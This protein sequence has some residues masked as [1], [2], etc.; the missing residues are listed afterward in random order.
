ML[1]IKEDVLIDI[2]KKVI[3]EKINAKEKV[4]GL[5]E[6]KGTKGILHVVKDHSIPQFSNKK[7]TKVIFN[8]LVGLYESRIV[9]RK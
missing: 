1:V 9:D 6:A 3:L 4:C 7:S 5:G 8:P 2:F